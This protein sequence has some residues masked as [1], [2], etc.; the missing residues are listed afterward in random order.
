[1]RT[2]GEKVQAY[3]DGGLIYNELTI[4]DALRFY[5]DRVWQTHIKGEN[6]YDIWFVEV[7]DSPYFSRGHYFYN[8]NHIKNEFYP[9]CKDKLNELL[10]NIIEHWD[11]NPENAI[12][13][14]ID[15]VVYMGVG[16]LV[17]SRET[18]YE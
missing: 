16:E 1:M 6:L 9:V 17:M 4:L 14:V 18:V 8:I 12:Y 15:D 7:T 3:Q 5:R 13:L 10:N 2:Y 11:Y